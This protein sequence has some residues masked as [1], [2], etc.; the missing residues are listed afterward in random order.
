[1]FFKVR[2]KNGLKASLYP[3]DFV[4][5][6]DMRSSGP[7]GGFCSAAAKTMETKIFQK[8]EKVFKERE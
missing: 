7:G 1:M 4:A 8:A 2:L 6:F 5:A 3:D